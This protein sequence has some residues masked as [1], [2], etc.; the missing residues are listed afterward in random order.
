MK[1]QKPS[2]RKK[3]TLKIKDLKTNKNPRA[4]GGVKPTRPGFDGCPT[5]HNETF[6]ADVS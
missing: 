1:S 6:L 4:G 2:N 3:A 5:N